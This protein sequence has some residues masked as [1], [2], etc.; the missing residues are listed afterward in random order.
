MTEHFCLEELIGSQVAARLNIKNIPTDA[1]M[2]ALR[3]TALH[4]ERI[5]DIAK[6]PIIILSGYRSKRL[7]M[8]VGGSRDSQHMYGEAADIA[9]YGYGSAFDLAK[10][11]K[12]NMFAFGV[13]QLIYEYRR[14]V[15][16]SFSVKP[17]QQVLTIFSREDGYKA[18]L[19]A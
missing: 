4:L 3:R 5:R 1:Q 11:I 17:R 15:H 18:G 8:A 14:W 6:S 9:C 16:V 19:F 10:L 12:D 7:N 13:D 2:I